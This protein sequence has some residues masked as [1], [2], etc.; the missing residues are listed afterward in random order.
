M[1][2]IALQEILSNKLTVL[3]N[4]KSKLHRPKPRTPL[5]NVMAADEGTI[6]QLVMQG[7]Q[8]EWTLKNNSSNSPENLM[9]MLSDPADAI[10]ELKILLSL[11]HF[12][13]WLLSRYNCGILIKPGQLF[14]L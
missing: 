6:E 5:Q 3:K 7:P 9:S 8:A 10:G 13:N 14:R 4:L 1:F 2:L 12:R 11:S